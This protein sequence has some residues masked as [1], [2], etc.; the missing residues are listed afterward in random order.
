[1]VVGTKFHNV[2]ICRPAFVTWII[3]HQYT[4]YR[5][6][7][8]HIAQSLLLET[9]NNKFYLQDADFCRIPGH[10][11]ISTKIIIHS[12][13]EAPIRTAFYYNRLLLVLLP[14]FMA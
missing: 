12:T 7:V 2:V 11:V 10:D 4:G 8:L 5:N 13:Q 1:M 6:Y 3:R 14:I 9:C